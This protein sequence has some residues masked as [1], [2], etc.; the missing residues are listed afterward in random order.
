MQEERF[1]LFDATV[2]EERA[3]FSEFA[4]A[5]LKNSRYDFVGGGSGGNYVDIDEYAAGRDSDDVY[6]S[7]EAFKRAEQLGRFIASKIKLLKDSGIEID[8]LAFIERDSGPVGMITYKDFLGTITKLETCSIRPR[9]RLL[10]SAVKGRPLRQHEK[11]V[12][13]NDVA[14]DGDAILSAADKI[15]QQGGVVAFAIVMFDR[16]EGAREHLAQY[17]IEL[18][19]IFDKDSLIKEGHIEKDSKPNNNVVQFIGVATTR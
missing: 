13:I 4:R 2:E 12:L 14:T 11:V 5:C 7:E 6:K 9:K 15:W 8:R 3:L 10:A 19:S 16:C 1:V 17:D 18:Y